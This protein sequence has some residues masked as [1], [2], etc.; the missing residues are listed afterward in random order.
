MI[1]IENGEYKLEGESIV[2][3]ATELTIALEII[4]CAGIL[5]QGDKDMSKAI[6]NSIC[7]KAKEDLREPSETIWEQAK[8]VMVEIIRRG[9]HDQG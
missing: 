8:D 9:R 5:E 2:K 7:D 6:I 4:G 3:I 1:H